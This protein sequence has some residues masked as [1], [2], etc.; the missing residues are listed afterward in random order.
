MNAAGIVGYAYQAAIR[1]PSCIVDW[2]HGES[3]VERGQIY[4]V[5]DSESSLDRLAAKWGI[6][7]HDVDTEVFPVPYL[8]GE[9]SNNASGYQHCDG[10][11]DCIDHDWDDCHPPD[12]IEYRVWTEGSDLVGI[13]DS[14]EEAENIMADVIRE[15]CEVHDDCDGCGILSLPEHHGFHIQIVNETTG[16]DVTGDP[17]Y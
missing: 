5:R 12:R 1:C 9:S 8:A 2:A 6:D 16:D 3:S 14:R 11:N 13:A 17:N 7:R 10:C 4:D 15:H